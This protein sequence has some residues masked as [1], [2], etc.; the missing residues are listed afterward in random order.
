[1]QH[2]PFAP[3]VGLV[4]S[5]VS[6]VQQEAHRWASWPGWRTARPPPPAPGCSSPARSSRGGAAL[7]PYPR[8]VAAHG[9]TMSRFFH[10]IVETYCRKTLCFHLWGVFQSF[11]LCDVSSRVSISVMLAP[12]FSSP[13]CSCPGRATLMPGPGSATSLVL[14]QSV[15]D[16]STSE[17]MQL[18][19][20]CRQSANRLILRKHPE[21]CT[22]SILAVSAKLRELRLS[23]PQ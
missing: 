20:L 8:S 6:H 7:A 2:L 19:R 9:R 21:R 3:F 11:H 10:E 17:T 15:I 13:A 16:S 4:L 14:H 1:M 22:Y 12:G 18:V 5:T 23:L